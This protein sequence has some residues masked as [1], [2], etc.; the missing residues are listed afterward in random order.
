MEIFLSPTCD[1]SYMTHNKCLHSHNLTWLETRKKTPLFWRCSIRGKM[2]TKSPQ[3]TIFRKQG[4]GL[5]REKERSGGSVASPQ[6]KQFRKEYKLPLTE[7]RAHERAK[8]RRKSLGEKRTHS[9]GGKC[10]ASAKLKINVICGCDEPNEGW[11]AVVG[12]GF[13]RKSKG[14][15]SVRKINI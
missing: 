13:A 11:F 14:R 6:T 2:R 9:S 15:G 7:T 5:H 12:E 10:G 3:L 1:T 8:G 4:Q